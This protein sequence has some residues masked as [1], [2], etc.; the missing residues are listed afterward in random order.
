MEYLLYVKYSAS[1]LPG[2]GVGALCSRRSKEGGIRI[3]SGL[4]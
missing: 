4:G 2:M 1:P 3:G